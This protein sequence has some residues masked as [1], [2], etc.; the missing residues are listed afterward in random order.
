MVPLMQSPQSE[1]VGGT[2]CGGSAA[3]LLPGQGWSVISQG[4]D[5]LFAEVK[6]RS[7][8]FQTSQSASQL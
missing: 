4:G 5:G 6:L 3:L 1:K 7:G 8:N 2:S